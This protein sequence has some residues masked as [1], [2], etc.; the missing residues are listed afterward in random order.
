MVPISTSPAH[1]S[2]PRAGRAKIPAAIRSAAERSAASPSGS[3]RRITARRAATNG[4]RFAASVARAGPIRCDRAEPEDVRQDER[5]ER[6]EGEER[7]DLPAEIPVLVA[8]L[9]EPDERDEDPR[10]RDD[11]GAHAGGRVRRASAARPR[12]STRPTSRADREPEDDPDVAAREPRCRSR[13]RRARRP[14]KET[15]AAS[16]KRRL[17]R[18]RPSASPKSAAKIGIAPRMSPI[19]EAVVMSSA[20]TKQSWLSQSVTAANAITTQM[21]SLDPKRPLDDESEDDEDRAGE[22]VP[23]RRVRERLQ[24]VL[25]DVLRDAQV[26][27]PEQDRARAA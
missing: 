1:G 24:S 22:A 8:R 13:P 5:P 20:R 15:A 6:R 17:R 26:E 19:V 9:R 27:R 18:S 10:E 21:A 23:D 2:R 11:D 4:C 14:A 3:E 7:P 12:R 25:E 16:Q